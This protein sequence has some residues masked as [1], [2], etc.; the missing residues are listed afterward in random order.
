MPSITFIAAS[1]V[2]AGT[3]VLAVPFVSGPRLAGWGGAGPVVEVDLGFLERQGFEGKAGEVAVLRGEDG[4][5]VMAVGVGEADE[6]SLEALRKAAAAVVKAAWR[7]TRAAT[8]LL[9]AVPPRSSARRRQ[10]PWP[11]ERAWRPTASVPTRAT[12]RRVGS[13]S[14]WW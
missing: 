6:V 1:E 3:E 12:S 4:T 5:A 14:W 13:K 10:P 9:D 8:T 11:R 2:P 7:S